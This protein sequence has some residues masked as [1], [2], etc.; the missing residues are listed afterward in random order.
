MVNVNYYKFKEYYEEATDICDI[1]VIQLKKY[2]PIFHTKY[3]IEKIRDEM[4]FTS[5]I[6]YWYISEDTTKIMEDITGT[7]I[8]IKFISTLP[9]KK[10]NTQLLIDII[11]KYL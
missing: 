4:P 2:I 9:Y 1:M 3:L 6:D 5:F 11:N 10:E 8:I 7:S